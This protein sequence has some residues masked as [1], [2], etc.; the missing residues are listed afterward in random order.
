MPLQLGNGDVYS[1]ERVEPKG[2]ANET[3][4]GAFFPQQEGPSGWP[5]F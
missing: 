4:T 5:V 2:Q 1:V 3:L